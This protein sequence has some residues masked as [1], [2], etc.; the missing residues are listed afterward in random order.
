MDI[1]WP[2]GGRVLG[3]IPSESAMS[4]F[5]TPNNLGLFINIWKTPCIS[6]LKI[7]KSLIYFNASNQL[8]YKRENNTLSVAMWFNFE[9]QLK[10]R[11][12]IRAVKYIS[13]YK[14]IYN[15]GLGGGW[16]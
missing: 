13:N 16:R 11:P 3:S 10:V 6:V 8:V 15:V 5:S 9:Y 4:S 12:A 7:H 2:S 14:T 1:T